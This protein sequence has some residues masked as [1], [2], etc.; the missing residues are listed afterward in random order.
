[1]TLLLALLTPGAQACGGFFPPPSDTAISNTQEV[2]FATSGDEVQVDY[3][4]LVHGSAAEFGWLIPIPGEFVSLEDG[5]GAVF[6]AIHEATDPLEDLVEPPSGGCLG[7]GLKSDGGG[8]FDTAS[9]GR[10]GG[11]EVVATGFTGTYGYTVLEATSSEAF[12]LW[13]DA[14]GLDVGPAGPTVDRYV[15]DGGWQFVALTLDGELADDQVEAPPISIRYTGG[16]MVYPARMSRTSMD[17]VQH[18]IV[19]VKGDQRARASAGWTEEEASLLWDDGETP[20]Y[21][22]SELWPEA[23]YEAGA[24]RRYLTVF[25]GEL[26]GEW[27]TRFETRAPSE[28][29]EAD[30]TFTLDGGTTT[31]HLLLSNRSGCA[32][33]EGADA[34]LVPGAL[35]AWWVGRR[36]AKRSRG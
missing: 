15:T 23:L 21:M 12:L 27:V 36:R 7:S 28:V 16:G 14:N 25:A 11:V 10:G 20:D 18:T 34:L 4:V 1:M 9:G 30:A 3:R 35:A 2:I 29:H 8:E 17:P 26:D 13:L 31:V 22:R 24:E 5:D 32:R 33:P 19:Y 6:Q